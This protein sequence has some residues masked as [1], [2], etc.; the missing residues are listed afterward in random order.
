MIGVIYERFVITYKHLTPMIE[1]PEITLSKWLLYFLFS[2][3]GSII[4]RLINSLWR[5]FE[6]GDPSFSKYIY[7]LLGFRTWECFEYQ[8]NDKENK[9]E[10]VKKP[11]APDYFQSSVIGCLELLVYPVL[12]FNSKVLFI[13]A[14]LAFKTVHRWGY[15]PGINR[16][17]Y[18]R[19][20]VSNALILI[21]SFIIQRFFFF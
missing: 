11:C 10:L 7:I 18:N 12:L 1:L 15:A 20:L 8:R 6:S 5:N 9:I 4:V 14:W 21:G 13:G 16:G 19:Y 17:F 2:V 3:I